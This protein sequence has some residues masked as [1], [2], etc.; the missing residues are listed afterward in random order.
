MTTFQTVL[1]VIT[2]L[3]CGFGVSWMYL[4]AWSHLYKTYEQE[5]E[6]EEKNEE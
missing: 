3:L 1:I 2:L 6:N 4:D 5:S